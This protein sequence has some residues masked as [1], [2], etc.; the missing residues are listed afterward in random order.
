[1]VPEKLNSLFLAV[2]ALLLLF[3]GQIPPVEARKFIGV[4]PWC[5]TAYHRRLC[6]RMVKGAANW[7]DAS[8]NSL[9]TTLELA[10]RL[11]GMVQLVKPA[12]ADLEQKSQESIMAT[13][14]EDFDGTIDDL[15]KSLGSLEVRDIGT[16]RSRLSAALSSE[17]DQALAEFGI[18][19]PLGRY[20]K[21]LYKEVDNCLAVI[22]QT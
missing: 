15:E 18:Q 10:K 20:A 8:V 13:C 16:A 3:A 6:T 17:C 21:V 2:A 12:I 19:S 7:H 4:N 9:R 1:M 22:L 5:R 11:Q 14:I